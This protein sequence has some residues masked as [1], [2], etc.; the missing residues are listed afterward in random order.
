MR[1]FEERY[2]IEF[3]DGEFI[4]FKLLSWGQYRRY[5]EIYFSNPDALPEIEEEI[6]DLCV[7]NAHLYDKNYLKAGTVST[8]AYA[9]LKLSGPNSLK[10][11]EESLT[12]ARNNISDVGYQ[13][14]GFV[15]KAFPAYKL[16]DIDDL[17]WHEFM[18]LVALSEQI[19]GKDIDFNQNQS[20]QNQHQYNYVN[21]KFHR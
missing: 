5:R 3:Q 15:C 20:M 12:I 11:V 1:L 21:K 4:V 19:L 8:V 7:Y 10:D 9:I 17:T 14:A 6:F 18:N 13:L 2:G 16:S